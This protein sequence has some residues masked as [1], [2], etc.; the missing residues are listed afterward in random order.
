MDQKYFRILTGG[1]TMRNHLG[2]ISQAIV[3]STK[4]DEKLQRFI[5][6]LVNMQL[7]NNFNFE[8]KRERIVELADKYIDWREL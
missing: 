1:K 4:D 6:D 5:F 3:Q 8:K 2:R 7:N